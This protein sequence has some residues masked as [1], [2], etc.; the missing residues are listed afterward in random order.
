V[1]AGGRAATT[2]LLDRLFDALGRQLR[3]TVEDRDA[4]LDAGMD[5]AVNADDRL[6]GELHTAR[7]LTR[8]LD[9]G[10]AFL[11]DGQLAAAL[12]GVPVKVRRTDLAFAE[13][14]VERVATW[15]AGLPNAR[16][17]SDAWQDFA[18]IDRDPRKPG[19]LHYWTPWG[20]LHLRLLPALPPAVDVV[21]GDECHQVRPLP[22]VEAD[23]PQLAR[24]VRRWQQRRQ[25]TDAPA[26]R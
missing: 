26:N 25:D 19:P 21:H 20:E 23:D 6:A 12:H 13:D 18:P 11:L 24:I 5:G 9:P 14:D 15:L 16:R 4:D 22:D 10:V 2:A 3:V 8:R 1:A 7:I 17:W